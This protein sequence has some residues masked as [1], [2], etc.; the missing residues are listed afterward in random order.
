MNPAWELLHHTVAERAGW[1]LLHSLWQGACIG[2]AFALVRFALR[3]HSA[4]VRY[5]AGCL[6]L[7]LLLVAPVLT[8]FVG[9]IPSPHISLSSAGPL[10]QVFVPPTSPAAVQNTHTGDATWLY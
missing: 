7:A 2:F 5:L 1:V 8:V 10:R 9:V 3:R 6:G 4:N